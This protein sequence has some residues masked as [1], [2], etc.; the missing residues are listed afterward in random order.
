M[1][2]RILKE[3][4]GP[5]CPGFAFTGPGDASLRVCKEILGDGI[6]PLFETIVVQTNSPEFMLSPIARLLG[7]RDIS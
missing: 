2:L 1:Y 3:P 5:H 4:I 7:E 6:K